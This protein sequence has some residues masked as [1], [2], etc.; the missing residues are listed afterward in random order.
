MNKKEKKSYQEAFRELQSIV[1]L[2]ENGDIQIDE[3]S[4]KIQDASAL[5]KICSD[6]LQ[7]TELEIEQLLKELSPAS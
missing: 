2:L 6:K 5:I 3:L 4:E 1:L 7:E